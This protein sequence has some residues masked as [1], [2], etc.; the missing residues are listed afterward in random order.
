MKVCDAGEQRGI[1]GDGV[2]VLG[3]L[4][5]H[6]AL[7]GLQV[8]VGVRAGEVPEHASHTVKFAARV[9]QCADCIGKGG[10]GRR[11]GDLVDLGPVCGHAALEGGEE[12]LRQKFVERGRL[13][14]R[15]P[16]LQ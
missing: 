8:V 14:G 1:R 15:I 10:L 3:Q 11:A 16:G 2:G 7:N 6:V 9:F 13:E 5:R 12:M 4:G